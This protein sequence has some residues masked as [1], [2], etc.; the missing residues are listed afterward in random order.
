MKAYVGRS[1]VRGLSPGPSSGLLPERKRSRT[2]LDTAS[3]APQTLR[4]ALGLAA[5]T[6]TAVG[7][8]Y[9][10][11][12]ILHDPRV[13]AEAHVSGACIAL[14]MA[15]A[16]GTVDELER[17]MTLRALASAL[18]P[19]FERFPEKASDITSTC[20]RLTKGAVSGKIAR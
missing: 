17:R 15:A 1:I 7:I 19:H 9:G 3:D 4:T 16:H 18:N 6:M 20:D 5:I 2:W 10:A 12:S 14:E 11:G 13:V 8:G